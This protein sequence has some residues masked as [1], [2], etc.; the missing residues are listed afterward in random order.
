M[1]LSDHSE[2]VHKSIQTLKDLTGKLQIEDAWNPFSGLFPRLSAWVKK[3]IVLGAFI[4][5]V[6]I[7]LIVCIPCLLT[8]IQSLTNKAL[9][10]NGYEDWKRHKI[11]QVESG[12]YFARTLEQ[13]GVQ[14]NLL[15]GQHLN[16]F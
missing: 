3:L 6:F 7:S 11:R 13:N 8:L 4:L 9:T 12:K 14:L 1:N 2:S 16:F 5:I 15:V 10:S